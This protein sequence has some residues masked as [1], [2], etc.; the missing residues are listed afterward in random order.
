MDQVGL[1]CALGID[2]H[3]EQMATE[4][5]GTTYLPFGG[6]FLRLLL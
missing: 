3:L 4:F 6:I 1:K 5:K 2:P